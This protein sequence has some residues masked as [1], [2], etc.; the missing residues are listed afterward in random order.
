MKRKLGKRSN[1]FDVNVYRLPVLDGRTKHFLENEGHLFRPLF[2]LVKCRQFLSYLF[3]EKLYQDVWKYF[4]YDLFLLSALWFGYVFIAYLP[5]KQF[6]STLIVNLVLILLIVPFLL[7]VLFKL[8]KSNAE[9]RDHLGVYFYLLDY[10]L[11]LSL[12]IYALQF[13]AFYPN[14]IFTHLFAGYAVFILGAIFFIFVVVVFMYALGHIHS[15]TKKKFFYVL[16]LFFMIISCLFIFISYVNIGSLDD[17]DI[18]RFIKVDH[19]R[20]IDMF[21]YSA[22]EGHTSQLNFFIKTGTDVDVL[23]EY[24]ETAL[25][26]AAQNNNLGSVKVLID[27]SAD[28]NFEQ[29]DNPYRSIEPAAVDTPLVSAVRAN[30]PEMVKFLLENGADPNLVVFEYEEN[31]ISPLMIAANDGY[32]EIVRLLLDN[33]VDV[34]IRTSRSEKTALAFAERQ[35]LLRNKNAY[36]SSTDSRRIRYEEFKEIVSMLKERSGE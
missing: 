36:A 1:S 6:L 2:L 13:L 7:W 16:A 3:K 9:L 22:E 25:M 34:S 11:L 33:G 20:S 19:Y 32:L 5:F 31:N 10:L 21:F 14:D 35:F 17:V 4:F 18:L 28:V 30:H 26:V 23:N 29:L 15:F 27:N 24:G 12:P 8:F